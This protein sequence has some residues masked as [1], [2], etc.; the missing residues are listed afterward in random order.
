MKSLLL[1]TALLAAAMT[2]PAIAATPTSGEAQNL[3]QAKTEMS[4]AALQKMQQTI[5]AD[6][7]IIDEL[8]L[9][10]WTL[11]D[12]PP[13]EQF[14]DIAAAINRKFPEGEGRRDAIAKVFGEDYVDTMAGTL[15]SPEKTESVE[16][17][18]GEA[19]K[20]FLSYE[21]RND[22]SDWGWGE[23]WGVT[24][25]PNIGTLG[26]GIQVGYEF[27]KYFK[28]RAHYGSGKISHTGTFENAPY[29]ASI[30]NNNNVGVF[31]DWHPRGSQFHVTAGLI[32]MDPRVKI[33]AKYRSDSSGQ[34]YSFPGSTKEY[35]VISDFEMSGDWENDVT[36][37]LGFGWSTDG[38]QARTLFFSIDIGVAYLGEGNYNKNPQIPGHN[39]MLMERP[40]G[41]SEADWRFSTDYDTA[42]TLL[43]LDKNI[44]D[45]L[46]KI[47]N[48]LND[49]YVYPVIQLGGGIRF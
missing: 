10:S 38:G 39:P 26:L 25:A 12:L 1:P 27:N 48:F 32:R 6:E 37:Y 49:M 43:E 2:V 22:V 15:D 44:R 30:K 8:E 16:K 45:G 4:I 40:L 9:S 23:A 41:G 21:N 18:L 11:E 7:A 33:T 29:H 24:I 34:T 28:I 47:A 35:R 19:H 36:P 20:L 17:L 3:P 14:R 46:D 13:D 42:S 31:F 5:E